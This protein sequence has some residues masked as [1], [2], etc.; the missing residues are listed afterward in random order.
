MKIQSHIHFKGQ[1]LESV[2]ST[3][4]SRASQQKQTLQ[5]VS[6]LTAT[7]NVKQHQNT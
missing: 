1:L 2:W 5:H 3:N 6:K 7:K 4:P